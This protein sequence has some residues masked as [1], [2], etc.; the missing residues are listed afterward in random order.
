MGTVCLRLRNLTTSRMMM[1]SELTLSLPTSA[2]QGARSTREPTLLGRPVPSCV[3]FVL[4]AKLPVLLG[5]PLPAATTTCLPKLFV[6]PFAAP[7]SRLQLCA[8]PAFSPSRPL[9]R[10]SDPYLHC[11]YK[12]FCERASVHVLVLHPFLALSDS[13]DSSVVL[14][15][16]KL[17]CTIGL[18][19]GPHSGITAQSSTTVE[20]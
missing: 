16:T 10:S 20:R 5:L 4:A 2:H 1:Q 6:W 3:Q 15:C 9:C 12:Q 17:R 11:Q 8:Q 13:K 14:S 18:Q 19:R 7:G